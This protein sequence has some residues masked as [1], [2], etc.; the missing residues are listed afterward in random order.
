VRLFG[1]IA[2]EGGSGLRIGWAI[3][4][5]SWLA[6][7]ASLAAM[8]IAV[9]EPGVLADGYRFTHTPVYVENPDVE[10]GRIPLG[11]ASKCSI[12]FVNNHL[13]TTR[14]IGVETSCGCTTAATV[15]R[16]LRPMALG[17]IRV[18]IRPPMYGAYGAPYSGTCCY[19][20]SLYSGSYQG[21]QYYEYTS[22]E[23]ATCDGMGCGG[24][25]GPS[26]EFNL[27]NYSLPQS[28]PPCS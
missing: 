13:G 23:S 1:K 20:G 4:V 3:E 2:Q 27:F 17:A 12:S 15:V 8:V 24:Q 21:Y 25:A 26:G 5:V 7:A 22:A 19:H 14:V 18:V 11:I 6:I 16:N 10:L 9:A 28:W